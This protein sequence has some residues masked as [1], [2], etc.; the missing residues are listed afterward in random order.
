[1]NGQINVMGSIEHYVR[2]T[3]RSI[4]HGCQIT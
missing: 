4:W 3:P 2:R 1:M